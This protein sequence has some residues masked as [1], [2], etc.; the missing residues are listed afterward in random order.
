MDDL[1]GLLALVTLG[2]V[3]RQRRKARHDD[4]EQG[5]P[6]E[7]RLARDALLAA[8]LRRSLLSPRPGAS[9]AA[10]MMRL[11]KSIASHPAH[12]PT[13]PEIEPSPATL[14][15]GNMGPPSSAAST[16]FEPHR[17]EP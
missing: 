4:L 7:V 2:R 12:V 13:A 16:S 9:H 1:H 15:H 8:K 14:A 11:R 5:P 3:L 10:L 6:T 17:W